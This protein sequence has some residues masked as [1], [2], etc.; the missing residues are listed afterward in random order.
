M[1]QYMVLFSFTDQGM[2]KIKESPARV[3]AAKETFQKLGANVKAFYAALGQDFDTVFLVE[4]PND[5]SVAKAA[6]AVS[7]AG[8]VRTR[9]I[10]LLSGGEFKRT[11]AALP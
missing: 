6:L 2:R 7:L 3:E 10:P 8:N 5:E 9:T 1:A 11:I 4:A